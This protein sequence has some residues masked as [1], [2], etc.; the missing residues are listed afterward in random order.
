MPEQRLKFIWMGTSIGAAFLLVAVLF[1]MFGRP[2]GPPPQPTLTPTKVT[3]VVKVSPPVVDSVMPPEFVT[4]PVEEKHDAVVVASVQKD[5]VKKT[6]GAVK[7]KKTVVAAQLPEEKA[8][9]EEAFPNGEGTLRVHSSPPDALVMLAGARK[10]TT[11]VNLPN[12]KS[13]K[14]IVEVV[15]KD[16][17]RGSC[18][19]KILPDRTTRLIYNFSE[20][21]CDTSGP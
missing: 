14:Y 3:E 12:V 6:T 20:K 2:P 11:P 13:G 19:V 8:P 21:R 16:K 17:V 4:P 5:E 15:G 1:V 9:V 10:G 18:A 7:P